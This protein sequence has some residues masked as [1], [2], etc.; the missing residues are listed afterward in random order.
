MGHSAVR[1]QRDSHGHRPV[2]LLR[3]L[4]QDLVGQHRV[5]PGLR[6]RDVAHQVVIHAVVLPLGEAA[7]AL[8]RMHEARRGTAD[9]RGPQCMDS[10]CRHIPVAHRQA[11]LLHGI[12]TDAR[13]LF[14]ARGDSRVRGVDGHHAEARAALHRRG[15][16]HACHGHGPGVPVIP[17]AAAPGA[18]HVPSRREGQRCRVAATAPS[19]RA[20]HL[21]PTLQAVRGQVHGLAH[22]V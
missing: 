6:S 8:V 1:R 5:V 20:I 9:Q 2:L 10:F 17:Q 19:A 18:Q 3:V 21:G 7:R 14:V 15:R 11:A 22:A 4:L 13:D 16:H 12:A